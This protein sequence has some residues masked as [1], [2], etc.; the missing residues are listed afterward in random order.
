MDYKDI[1]LSNYEPVLIEQ[2]NWI[3]NKLLECRNRNK[4]FQAAA[5]KVD[6]L[7][8]ASISSNKSDFI[9]NQNHHFLFTFDDRDKL[10]TGGKHANLKSIL[11]DEIL[12]LFE[13]HNKDYLYKSYRTF[14]KDLGNFKGL[15]DSIR[16]YDKSLKI[17]E[18]YYNSNKIDQIQLEDINELQDHSAYNKLENQLNKEEDPVVQ[19]KSSSHDSELDLKYSNLKEAL[20]LFTDDDKILMCSFL[21]TLPTKIKVNIPDTEIAR[22]H[23]ICQSIF[24]IEV[25]FEQGNSLTYMRKFT[26]GINYY[27]N[28]RKKL[29]L[30]NS[31]LLK[32]IKLPLPKFRKIFDDNI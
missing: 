13:Q 2:E 27:K 3:K 29:E 25:F 8:R 10:Y 22:I 9:K 18:F 28:P 31:V 20:S 11:E 6:Q 32:T 7:L 5:N 14:L 4:S 26:L 30:K 16:F 19:E 15:Y 17:V 23:Y 24:G 1:Y 21:F 12:E